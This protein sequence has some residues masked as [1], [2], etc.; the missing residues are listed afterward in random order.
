MATKSKAGP[1]KVAK[2]EYATSEKSEGPSGNVILDS[3]RALKKY[4]AMIWWASGELM[5]VLLFPL[6]L[7]TFPN[8]LSASSHTEEQNNLELAAARFLG[9]ETPFFQFYMDFVTL[10]DAISFIHLHTAL[11]I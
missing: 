10:Y 11:H 4:C 6:T 2:V 8:S 7:S 9:L 1:S 5:E 3:V